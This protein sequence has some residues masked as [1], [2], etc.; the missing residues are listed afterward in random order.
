MDIRQIVDVSSYPIDQPGDTAREKLVSDVRRHLANDGCAVIPGFLSPRGLSTL[1]AEARVRLSKTYYSPDRRCN[2]Y[3]DQGDPELPQSHP[4]NRFLERSN[5]FITADCFG[6]DSVARK[7]YYWAPLANF[8]AH[9][10]G[11]DRLHIY[12]DPVSNMIVNVGRAEEQFNWHFDTNEFTITMLLQAAES[13]GE[14]EY[15]PDLR[16]PQDE[17]YDAVGRVLDGDRSTVRR[18]SLN[19]GDLQIFLGRYALHRVTPVAGRRERL[20][21]IMSFTEQPGVIG[22][23][24][25]VRKLYGKVTQVHHDG[26]SGRVRSD[27]LID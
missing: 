26:A 12:A 13:G 19:P 8:I 15:A 23:I 9:C 6:D 20:L 1:C 11:R 10:L 18:L 27:A 17:R 3:F 25:R 24:E 5:G 4:R 14:F 16:S 7:L 22:S 21:L 2:V